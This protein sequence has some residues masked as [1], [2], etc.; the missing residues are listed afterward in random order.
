[1]TELLLDGAQKLVLQ[2]GQAELY[3]C[4]E[5]YS[6]RRTEDGH[7]GVVR[8][9]YQPERKIQTGIGP[10]TVKIPKERA[11]IG[12]PVTFQ[13]ALVSPYVR[14]TK[15][16]EATLPWLYLKGISTGEMGAALEVLVGPNVK[17]LLA[18]TV[19]RLKQAWAQEYRNWREERLD[20]DLVSTEGQ[21]GTAQYL[22]S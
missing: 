1:M 17:G 16:L 5:Q 14:K 9:G 8:N 22:A 11:K 7:A 6:T 13:S 20:K 15:S 21:A 2:A 18:S 10:V 3:A 4:L 12:E 19:S